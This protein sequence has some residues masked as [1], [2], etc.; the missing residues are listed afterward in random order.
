VLHA[1]LTCRYDAIDRFAQGLS[2]LM[3]IL[4]GRPTIRYQKGSPL[5]HALAQSLHTL[6]YK[7]VV[8]SHA[9]AQSLHTLVYKQVV[10]YVQ[11]F[12]SQSLCSYKSSHFK[13]TTAQSSEVCLAKGL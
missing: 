3:L 9:L 5:S 1:F 8:L 2:A 10:Q 13:Y 6:V 7:Q 12:L 11:C 4:R